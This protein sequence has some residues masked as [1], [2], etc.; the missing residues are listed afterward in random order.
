[1]K[2]CQ[3]CKKEFE[4]TQDDK[5]FYKKI[6]V[7]EPTFCP[8]CRL[9]RRLAWKVNLILFNRKCDLCGKKGLS[10]YEKE[11]SFVVYCHDCWWSDRWDFKDYAMDLD[12]SK[13]FLQQ[14]KEL[15][16]KTPVLGLSIDKI[17][18]ESSPYTNHCGHSKNCYMIYFSNHNE[19]SLFGYQLINS[20]DCLDCGVTM[21]SQSCYDCLHV[22]KSSNIINGI[23]NN[24]S[25]YD[26]SF[27]RDCEG[28]HDCFCVA[29]EKNSAYVFMGQK[30]S[31]ENY[32]KK[33]KEIDLG[34]YKQY[35]YWKN[36][37]N[38]YL[39]KIFPK[40]NWETLSQDVSGS[41]VFHSQNCHQCFDV[42]NCKDSK[43]LMLI[44]EGLVK[45]SYDY[46]EWGLN[47]ELVYESAVI[48]ENVSN[49]KFCQESGFNINN[50]EYSKLQTGGSDCFGCVSVKQGKYYILNKQYTKE[51]YEELIL[52]IKQHMMDMPYVDKKGRVYKYGEFFPMEFSLHAYNNSFANLFFPKTK[53]QT[54]EEGLFWNN[55]EIRKHSI[56]IK[57]KNLPDNIKDATEEIL[58][59]VIECSV[60]S[61]GYKITKQELDLTK[62]LNVP[63]SRKCPFCRVGEKVNEWVSQMKQIRRSCSK[64][65]E[66]FLTHFSKNKA[67]V[68]YCKTCYKKEVY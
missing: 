25:C 58:K 15:L 64:C 66:E 33:M 43:F 17:T 46:T 61:R 38:E 2:N 47:A 9:Q 68:I 54:E 53:E 39:T 18:G 56:T 41:Y 55:S 29:N 16:N 50:I 23:G 37:F 51:E 48:G 5:S 12:F 57:A 60:C 13:P 49:I 10:M 3:N 4:I 8:E 42:I 6:N 7:P 27:I 19:D 22:Y 21:K 14:W 36:K 30:L 63:L 52:K 40:P 26:S 34:S 31:K 67:P 1:M 32:F 45:D 62:K 65:G 20:K 28:V 59:E 35:T 24:R 11:A 44:Q